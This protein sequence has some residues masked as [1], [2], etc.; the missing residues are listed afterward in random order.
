MAL[1]LTSRSANKCLHSDASP[2]DGAEALVEWLGRRT[3]ARYFLVSRGRY[4]RQEGQL[5][6]ELAYPLLPRPEWP[7]FFSGD[8][9]GGQG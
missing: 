2:D 4:P 7:S 1:S 3:L 9:T 5:L 8:A 6:L